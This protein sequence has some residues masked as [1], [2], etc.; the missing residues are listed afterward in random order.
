MK[1]LMNDILIALLIP[2]L[3]TNIV[4]AGTV[5]QESVATSQA[6]V[7][8]YLDNLMFQTRSSNRAS[9]W[10]LTATYAAADFTSGTDPA[11]SLTTAGTYKI[12]ADL[13]VQYA[14]AAYYLSATKNITFKLRRTNNTAADLTNTEVTNYLSSSTV[15]GGFGEYDTQ[16]CMTITADDYTTT[17]TNDSI[18]VF[19]DLQALPDAGSVDVNY[20]SIYAE[21]IF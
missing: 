9:T 14:S 4:N 16:M 7:K 17:N 3:A 10:Q 15:G 21:R 12:E 2:L 8:T 5:T 20:L 13:C 6:T 19:G 1:K 11:V 18:T